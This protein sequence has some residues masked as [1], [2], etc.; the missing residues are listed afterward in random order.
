MARVERR[1]GCQQHRARPA[2]CAPCV[3]CSRRRAREDR[4]KQS[5][6][7]SVALKQPAIVFDRSHARL[8]QMLR[9]RAAVA[10]PAV[11][12]DV[13]ENLRAIVRE[14]THFIGK[15][16]LVADE[17]A[18]LADLRHQAVG[19]R[20]RAQIVQPPLSVLRQKRT[21]WET[22]EILRRGQDELCRNVVLHSP[23]G[24]TTEA[25]LKIGPS[26]FGVGALLPIEP[27]TVEECVSRAIPL[28]TSRNLGSLLKNGAGDSGQT[29][30]SIFAFASVADLIVS[31][32]RSVS[33]C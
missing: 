19:A 28:T 12:G 11:V 31:C 21:G 9:V 10:I 7:V 30:R 6:R 16:R 29:I 27:T 15:Y 5:L 2:L 23:T 1:G 20:C 22:E 3:E 32:V 17:D 8:V 13:H 4:S 14:L 26:V 24:V 18:E 25:E 33:V